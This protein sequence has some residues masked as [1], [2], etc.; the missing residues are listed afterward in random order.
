[1]NLNKVANIALEQ[2]DTLGFYLS[3]YGVTDKVNR[4]NL[5][6]SAIVAKNHLMGEYARLELRAKMRIN[7]AEKLVA[8][9]DQ[10][11]DELISLAPGPIA[12]QLTKAKSLSESL[13][14]KANFA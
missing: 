5:I 4:H 14:R 9:L 10:Q 2:L 13:I 8:K 12:A 11:A 3:R 6:A 1:M 7:R